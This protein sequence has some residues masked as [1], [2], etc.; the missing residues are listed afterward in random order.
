MLYY[1]RPS[2]VRKAIDSVFRQVGEWELAIID[3][4]EKYPIDPILKDF[5]S[6]DSLERVKV[7]KTGM[8]TES[9]RKAKGSCFGKF[10]NEAIKD[11]DAELALMLCDD[12]ML[13]PGVIQNAHQHFK[14]NPEALAV[15]CPVAVFDSET[16]SE[17]DAIV[18]SEGRTKGKYHWANYFNDRH[19]KAKSLRMHDASQVIWKTE[20]NKEGNI[21]FPYPKTGCLDSDF[22]RNLDNK[23][24]V[25]R[26]SR[27]DFVSQYKNMHR[28]AL[29]FRDKAF[30][31]AELDDAPPLKV[32]M[33]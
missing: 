17:Y 30:S 18:T 8:T 25:S 3:D 5:V 31:K 28:H 21:W 7:Y 4:S 29:S 20:C 6:E 27:G 15:W 33:L 14:N 2:M 16:E 26:F 10:M 22:Y 9:K 19:G 32:K 12:D 13:Y 24:N 11:S 23:Y 1:E